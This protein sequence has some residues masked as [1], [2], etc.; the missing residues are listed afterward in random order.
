[1]LDHHLADTVVVGLFDPDD[2]LIAHRDTRGIGID[3]ARLVGRECAERFGL[4]VERAQR[5]AHRL[6][7]F[8]RV[9]AERRTAGRS[10]SQS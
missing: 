9:G 7:E 3:L 8:K 4:S 6:K 5:H 1:M 2:D 10:R